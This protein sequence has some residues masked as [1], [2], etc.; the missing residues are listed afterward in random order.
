[1][2]RI[3][4]VDDSPEVRETIRAML[5]EAGLGVV[6]A[7]G[8]KEAFRALRARPV[9]LV[10]CDIFMANLDGLEI[11]RALRKAF[12]ELKIV[13]MSDGGSTVSADIDIFLVAM[14]LGADE[15]LYR[16]LD[17][18]YLLEVI[19]GLLKGTRPSLGGAD[20]LR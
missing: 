16:P 13:A 7:K 11:I 5:Q 8:G 20:Q 6:E 19:L 4:I 1:M 10:L 9:D 2:A 18:S 15:V 17:Q 3:L 14:H 12:P